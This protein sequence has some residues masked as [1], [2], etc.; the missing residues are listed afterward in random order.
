MTKNEE[1]L[2]IY[3]MA[4]QNKNITILLVEDNPGDVRLIKEALKASAVLKQLFVV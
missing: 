4:E 2:F 3:I 1:V